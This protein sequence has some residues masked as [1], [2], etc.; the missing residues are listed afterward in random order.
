MLNSLHFHNP[1]T[2]WPEFLCHFLREKEVLWK[3]FCALHS[4]AT[5]VCLRTIKPWIAIRLELTQC[6]GQS[7]LRAC[8]CGAEGGSTTLIYSCTACKIVHIDPQR[9]YISGWPVLYRTLPRGTL[10]SP[11]TRSDKTYMGRQYHCWESSSTYVC[12]HTL[13]RVIWEIRYEPAVK[14]HLKVK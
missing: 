14:C 10:L 7:L 1:R 12:E 2:N 11:P 3:S 8:A 6:S 9:L 5:A 13:S 4:W